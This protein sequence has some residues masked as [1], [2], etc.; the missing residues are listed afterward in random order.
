M[1]IEAKAALFRRG[2]KSEELKT[3]NEVLK[4][5]D[6]IDI[7]PA[8]EIGHYDSI[9]KLLEKYRL[10]AA[11]AGHLFCLKQ[12]KKLRH[13]VTFVCFD[14]ELIQAARK[15]GIPVFGYS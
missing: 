3:L 14:E 11:D 10:R 12:A 1:E 6:F 13:D 4:T 5:F 2:A 8:P 15:E 9:Q 7:D